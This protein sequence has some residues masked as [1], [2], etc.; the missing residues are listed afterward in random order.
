MILIF[1]LSAHFLLI[2]CD[3][4][5][6]STQSSWLCVCWKFD[7]QRGREE[8]TGVF[9]SSLNLQ[10]TLFICLCLNISPFH[11]RWFSIYDPRQKKKQTKKIQCTS[12]RKEVS[13]YGRHSSCWSRHIPGKLFLFILI[14]YLIVTNKP[15]VSG[16]WYLDPL[17]RIKWLG[18][19]E[20][21][22]LTIG[23]KPGWVSYWACPGTWRVKVF[24]CIKYC[25][26][27]R[28]LQHLGNTVWMSRCALESTLWMDIQASENL[29]YI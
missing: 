28:L 1:T 26:Q 29:P 3:N 11:P 5:Q 25:R 22:E 13:N 18:K 6:P 27:R 10:N 20:R 8:G 15:L 4:A 19:K 23:M 21:Q 2:H 9:P 14:F 17:Y 7:H 12:L 16:Q 24:W